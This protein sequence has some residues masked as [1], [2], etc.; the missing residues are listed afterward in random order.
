[1]C[2]TNPSLSTGAGQK[3]IVSSLTEY[4]KLHVIM[5]VCLTK[6][7]KVETLHHEV[8]FLLFSMQT[9]S[10]FIIHTTS[11]DGHLVLCL[12]DARREWLGT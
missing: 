12:L 7:L 3:M 1:M 4:C 2:T 5:N 11:L 9:T 10:A 6:T 8:F